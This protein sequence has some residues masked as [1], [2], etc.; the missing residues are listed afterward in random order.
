MNAILKGYGDPTTWGGRNYEPATAQLAYEGW[1]EATH[2][3]DILTAA[4]QEEVLALAMQISHETSE[5]SVALVRKLAEIC[6]KAEDRE[7]GKA[8][9]DSAESAA[10]ARAKRCGRVPQ[11][12]DD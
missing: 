11:G 10:L 12:Y 3:A 8:L 5:T 4:E 9:A 2:A 6:R 1:A 7:F